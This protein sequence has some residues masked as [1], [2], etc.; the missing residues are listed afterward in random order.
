[1]VS[2]H[3]CT[4]EEEID[5]LTADIGAL[6][7]LT[8]AH[9]SQLA[10]IDEKLGQAPQ[11]I[12]RREGA[13]ILGAMHEQRQDL[14]DISA[15]MGSIGLDVRSILE[16]SAG[17]LKVMRVPTR[18]PYGPKDVGIWAAIAALGYGVG[19]AAKMLLAVLGG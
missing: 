12:P 19:E 7:S 1:M 11:V 15:A 18:K 10:A 3:A 9:S 4:K 5:G 6:R 8:G 2:A 14:R 17:S 13:G 16:Q